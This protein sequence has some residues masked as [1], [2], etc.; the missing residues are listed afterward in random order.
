MRRIT[1]AAAHGHA[2]KQVRVETQMKLRH[3]LPIVCAH[4]LRTNFMAI[5]ASCLKLSITTV[6]GPR[7]AAAGASSVN[8]SNGLGRTKREFLCVRYH[9]LRGSRTL[10]R[11]ECCLFVS[12]CRLFRLS[13]AVRGFC[14]AVQAPPTTLR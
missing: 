1:L 10:E 3:N 9:R 4:S 6:V 12:R 5:A 13:W 8:T 7:S 2:D 14:D 11:R